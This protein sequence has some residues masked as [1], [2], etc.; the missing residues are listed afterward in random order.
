MIAAMV[1]VLAVS[2][3]ESTL[4]YSGVF[5]YL[6][7]DL[8]VACGDL[9]FEYLEFLVTM[10]GKPLAWVPGNHDPDLNGRATGNWLGPLAERQSGPEGC[11]NVDGRV[12]DIAGLRIG[13]LGGSMRYRPGPH[14]YTEN[15]MRS[16][17]WRL[18][19]A[20]TLKRPRNARRLDLLVTHAPPFGLGDQDDICHR[21]FPAF[22][23]LIDK[24]RP[25]IHIHGHIHPH[26]GSCPDR[27]LGDTRI[28]NAVPYKLLELER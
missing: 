23:Q 2:D 25:S 19:L 9:P 3:E 10:I 13:G 1:R 26:A 14:Q 16:R 4:A 8:I 24:A 6:E 18:V 15:Q 20:A 22:S 27:T 28:V 5:Q 21:G 17:S 12:V 11:T 7:P